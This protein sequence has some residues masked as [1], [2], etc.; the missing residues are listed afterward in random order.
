MSSR[1]RFFLW[2]IVLGWVMLVYGVERTMN[3][4]LAQAKN[5]HYCD[6]VAIWHITDG[7]LG[8]PPY[9]GECQ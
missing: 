8:W 2:S 5:E 6:M 3:D 9:N 4:D 1:Q 7:D